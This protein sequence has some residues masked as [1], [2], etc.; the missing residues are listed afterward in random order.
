[1]RAAVR[2]QSLEHE[3]EFDLALNTGMRRGEQYGLTWDRVDL[4]RGILT[5]YGK[6]GRRFVRINSV[7]R[8]AILHL[9]S[10][11]NGSKF[12]CPDKQRED[13]KDW[14]TWLDHACDSAKIDNFLWHDL[15]HTFASR[16]VMAGVDLRN[17]QE[18]LGHRTIITTQRYAH[19]SPDHQRANVEKLTR[20]VK[21]IVC[22]KRGRDRRAIH[23]SGSAGLCDDC[24]GETL[25]AMDT[26]VGT[27]S[28]AKKKSLRE[29]PKQTAGNA[30]A[31]RA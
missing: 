16:L 9:H 7:A 8:A 27:Q 17:V 26:F 31:R 14:R 1:M 13:Q 4:E 25:R 21:C 29:L 15:R 6:T 24:F 3:A 22:V 11:S 5:V 30:G 28:S 23:V 2:S 10:V 18:L 19:L 12:V 20:E